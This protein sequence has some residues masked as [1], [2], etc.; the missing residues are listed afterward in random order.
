MSSDAPWIMAAHSPVI[1][2]TKIH[3]SVLTPFVLWFVHWSWTTALIGLLIVCV[4][5]Y[6]QAKGRTFTWVF[7]RLLSALRG[8]Y[9]SARPIWYRRRYARLD[10]YQNVNL[11]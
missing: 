5:I 8:Q 9:V 4:A 11:H 6:I 2:G 1:P 3:A 10:S 7:R